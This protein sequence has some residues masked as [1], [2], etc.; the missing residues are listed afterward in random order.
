MSECII[1]SY[2]ILSSRVHKCYVSASAGGFI[3]YRTLRYKLDFLDDH[4]LLSKFH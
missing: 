1:S 3:S 4:T 2:Q